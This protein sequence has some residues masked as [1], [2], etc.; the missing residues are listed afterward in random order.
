MIIINFILYYNVIWVS[1]G[2]ELQIDSSQIFQI[3]LRKCRRI[4]ERKL[5]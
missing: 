4:S 5:P 2:K 3:C 1:Q